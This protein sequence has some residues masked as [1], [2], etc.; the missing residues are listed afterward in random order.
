M[1]AERSQRA[2]SPQE[3]RRVY[4]RIGRLQDWQSFYEGPAIALLVEEA[5]FG[6][7]TSVYELGCGTGAFARRLLSGEL[8][9]TATYRGI[10]VSETMTRLATDRLA[11]WPERA[12]ITKVT[13]EF[14]LPGADGSFDRFVAIYVFDL[15]DGEYAARLLEEA[16][17]LLTPR[18][19]LCL[20]SLTEGRTAVGKTVSR[21]WRWAWE[22]SPRL[23]GG[24]RP[25]DL[26]PLLAGGWDIISQRS[27]SS[28]GVTSQVLVAG[29]GGGSA[30]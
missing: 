27:V 5:D 19:R 23:V 6:S 13:G 4:N 2:L 10:D 24:C 17:R 3:L 20:V 30:P 15:L 28:W 18:G 9:A 21:T 12:V 16:R 1:C 11:P 22:R 25:V 8:D 7:A 29:P 14:P 26:E